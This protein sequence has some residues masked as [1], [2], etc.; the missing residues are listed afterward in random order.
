[1][2][3]PKKNK[4][5]SDVTSQPNKPATSTPVATSKGVAPSAAPKAAI[6]EHR[7][8]PPVKPPIT[9]TVPQMTAELCATIRDRDEKEREAKA[10][11]FDFHK[12]I[13][14]YDAIISD[15]AQKI[16]QV[17]V[18]EVVNHEKN[19]VVYKSRTTGET[20][21]VR[22]ISFAD[23]QEKLPLDKPAKP[24]KGTFGQLKDGK[25][26]EHDHFGPVRI[27]AVLDD[28]VRI[29]TTDL[30]EAPGGIE[31]GRADWDANNAYP[32]ELP[33]P[34]VGQRWQIGL[35][36][37]HACTVKALDDVGAVVLPEGK[38][39]TVRISRIA[40]VGALPLIPADQV[41]GSKKKKAAGV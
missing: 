29:Q 20:I 26:W 21:R 23:K 17:D 36:D 24:P 34:E 28:A 10:V 1:M 25:V 30:E 15:L 32:R 7:A 14:N 13:K 5:T 31:V 6:E 27:L 3:R 35:D 33:K 19:I 11:A 38:T 16:E 8:T 22:P 41:I 9:K 37:I 39:E 2:G 40:F 12:A 4:G 18:E